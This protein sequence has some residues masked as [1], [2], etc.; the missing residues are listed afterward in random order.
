[1]TAI[2]L[3]IGDVHI[4]IVD[5]TATEDTSTIIKSVC[6]V[7]CPCLIVEFLLIVV[8]AYLDIIEVDIC[9]RYGIKMTITDKALVERDVRSTKYSTTLTTTVGVTLNG[10]QSINETGAV[11][12]TDNDVCLTKDVT[13]RGFADFTSVIAYATSPAATIDVTGRSPSI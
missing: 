8:R 10:G 5:I 9:C 6:T 1:M 13:C 12:L 7:T 3:D 11:E 4:T 2:H